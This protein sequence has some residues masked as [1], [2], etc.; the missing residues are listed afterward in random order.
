MYWCDSFSGD[1]D[2]V[3]YSTKEMDNII[4]RLRL[5]MYADTTEKDATLEQLRYMN[6]M[7]NSA[8]NKASNRYLVVGYILGRAV[9]TTWELSRYEASCLIDELAGEDGRISEGSTLFI[10]AVEARVEECPIPI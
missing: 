2:M 7:I 1:G 6:T 8:L 4:R 10:K 9:T 5:D 3:T